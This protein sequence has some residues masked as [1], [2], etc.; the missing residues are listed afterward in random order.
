M[1]K[2]TALSSVIAVILLAAAVK[3]EAQQLK[4]PRIGFL[5]N[6]PHAPTL[7][8]FR[9]GL[10]DFGYAEGQNILI[11]WRFTEG[12]PGRFPELA[13]ELVRLN[14]DV[15]VAGASAAVPFLERNTRAIPIVMISYEGDPVADGTV[16]SLARPGGNITGL[17]SLAPEL[18]GK[19]L[20]LLKE[21]FPKLLRVAVMW[22]PDDSGAR[23]QWDK[24]QAAARVLSLQ[25]LSL[26]VRAPSELDK[27]MKAAT[28]TRVDALMVLRGGLYLLRKQ[29]VVLAAKGRLPGMYFAGEFVE[30]GGLMS[31]GSNNEA[32]Y[33]RAA[34]YVDKILKGAKPADLPVEQPQKFELVINLKAAKQIGLTIPPNVL[35]R[36]DRVIR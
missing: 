12:K 22:N 34:Y 29:I 14:P 15:I 3:A 21:T 5:A 30:A 2:V 7:E 13:A 26:E 16:T 17:A 11:E 33:R 35:A 9:Q 19:Q 18:S 20:E 4:I 23:S 31:Y 27:V 24:T 1:K 32:Q 36:A 25:L 28:R 8:T 10:N 6:D